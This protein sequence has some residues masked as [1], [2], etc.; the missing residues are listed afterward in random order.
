MTAK[1]SIT[2]VLFTIATVSHAAKAQADYA[3]KDRTPRSRCCSCRAR[4]SDA[5][6]GKLTLTGVETV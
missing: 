5:A 1:T 3:V 2:L 4:R 6:D